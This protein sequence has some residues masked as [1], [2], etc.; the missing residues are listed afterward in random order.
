MRL[1]LF[2][3]LIFSLHNNSFAQSDFEWVEKNSSL[4]K[5]YR[6]KQRFPKKFLQ[7]IDRSKKEIANH[8]KK[9]N[10]GCTNP[11]RN[12]LIWI[13]KDNDG[14]CIVSLS[15]GGRF[16]ANIIYFFDINTLECIEIRSPHWT[17]PYTLEQAFEAYKNEPDKEIH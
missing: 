6:P 14:N 7:Y 10:P 9:W 11:K 2:I 1:L 4:F 16:V 17:R 8:R 3:L 13:A 15:S 12:Q 5:V